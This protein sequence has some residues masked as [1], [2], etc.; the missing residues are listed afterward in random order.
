MDEDE[1]L[2][3]FLA[4]LSPALG[5]AADRSQRGRAM[6]KW[7]VTP[8]R[9]DAGTPMA[10]DDADGYY[11]K[12]PEGVFGTVL[13]PIMNA[14]D[15]LAST[16]VLLLAAA[17]KKPFNH[18]TASLL[19]MCRTAIESS[20]QAIWVMSPKDRTTRRARAAGLAKVGIEHAREFHV[21]TIKAHENGLQLLTDKE[22]AQSRHRLK[23]HE[24]ELKE[25][26]TLTQ[27]NARKYSELVRKAAN[28]LAD[29]PPAH[30][31]ETSKVHYQT[32][33]KLEYRVCSSFTHGHGWPTDLVEGPTGMFAKM[34]DSLNLAL[35]NTECAVA[36]FEAQTTDPKTG[37]VNYYP[38]RLQVTIDEWRSQY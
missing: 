24:G 30:T 7:G 38:E 19:S 14:T 8:H 27:E 2:Y 1:A 37:R 35:L 5:R 32:I 13:F 25:L 21:E 4:L 18:H 12:I 34:A 28:W 9:P 20:A 3:A 6:E 36:L 15:A 29:N 17:N 16:N 22:L 11:E 23:F 10:L 31:D 33:S 26:E